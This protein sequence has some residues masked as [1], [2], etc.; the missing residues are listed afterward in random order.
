MQNVKSK[1]KFN[2]IVSTILEGKEYLLGK[3]RSY[4]PREGIKSIK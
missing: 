3:G 2:N 1:Y 4:T